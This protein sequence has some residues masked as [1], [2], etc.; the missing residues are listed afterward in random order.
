[1]I[2]MS[3]TDWQFDFSSLPDWNLRERFRD[4]HDRFFELPQSDTLVCIYSIYE[5]TMC[6]NLGSLAILKNKQDPQ[7]IAHCSH[8]FR[9][10]FSSSDDGNLI[11]LS[12][13]VYDR[14]TNRSKYPILILDIPNRRF[15]YMIPHCSNSSFKVLQIKPR[16]FVIDAEPRQLKHDKKLQ[17]LHGKKIH[18]SFRRWYDFSR[19]N[20][21]HDMIF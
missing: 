13:Q 8:P 10:N 9:V 5:V 7:L 2:T 21:L 17:K 19:L 18:L 20:D 6:N 3:F 4:A 14:A 1:V 16:S 12:L 15:S 11:F